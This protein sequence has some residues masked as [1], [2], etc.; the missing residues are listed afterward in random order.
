MVMIKC[1]RCGKTKHKCAKGLCKS[2]YDAKSYH[3]R[4][5][6]DSKYR[7]KQNKQKKAWRQKNKEK[8]K[9]S[10]AKSMVKSLPKNQKIE[11]YLIL[12][13]ELRGY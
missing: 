1:K 9:F 5:H 6:S 13:K 7:K 3:D 10:V 4:Y 11:I 12:K 2:C 8:F